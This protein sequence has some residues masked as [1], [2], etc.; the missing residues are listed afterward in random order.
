MT[1]VPQYGAFFPTPWGSGP[2]RSIGSKGPPEP[3]AKEE[4]G[5]A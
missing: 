4:G 1:P 3:K 5:G 2:M